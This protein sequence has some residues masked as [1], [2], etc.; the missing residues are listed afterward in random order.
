MERSIKRSIF[1]GHEQEDVIEYR[2]IFLDEIK[3]LL[4]YFV[5]FPDDGSMLPKTYPEDCAVGGPDWK[6][7]IMI[8]NDESIFFANDF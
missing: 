8:T 2:E 4:P 3:S 5:E 1:A 7:I 6:P